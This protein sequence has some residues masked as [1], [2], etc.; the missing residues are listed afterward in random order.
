MVLKHKSSKLCIIKVVIS[1]VLIV[2]ILFILVLFILVLLFTLL[3]ILE[4]LKIKD[5]F[6]NIISFCFAFKTLINW[7]T[8]T[9]L[10]I[11]NKDP[12][13]LK[14]QLKYVDGSQ[15]RL[16]FSIVSF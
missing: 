7:N 9:K 16:S 2:L 8:L 14:F 1:N 13:K 10:I 4:I 5:F 3:L 6:P 11:T 12:I 15:Q